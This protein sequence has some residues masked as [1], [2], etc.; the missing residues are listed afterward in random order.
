MGR[1]LQGQDSTRIP[2]GI[3]A[4]YRSRLEWI[5]RVHRIWWSGTPRT[6]GRASHR[7]VARRE[8]GICAVPVTDPGSDRGAPAVRYAAVEIKLP[9]Q[10]G[11][12]RV[13]RHDES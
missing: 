12:R 3:P 6:G 1:G 7:D 9:T 8:H 13:D 4:V 2:R 10:D 5:A 11:V